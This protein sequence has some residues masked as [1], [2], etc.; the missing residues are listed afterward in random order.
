MVQKNGKEVPHSGKFSWMLKSLLVRGKN[1][2]GVVS[3]L[4]GI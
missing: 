3:R 2:V 1:F 4:Y